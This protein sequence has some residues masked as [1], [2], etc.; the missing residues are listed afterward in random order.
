MRLGRLP[1]PSHDP[2]SGLF[3]PVDGSRPW[4]PVSLVEKDRPA[5]ENQN[6]SFFKYSSS[7]FFSSSGSCV[8][9]S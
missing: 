2:R 3:A 4:P 8:P 5:V 9:K 1:V 6:Y 7:A